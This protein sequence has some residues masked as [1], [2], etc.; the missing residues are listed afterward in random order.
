M[1]G[2]LRREKLCGKLLLIPELTFLKWEERV[3][4]AAVYFKPLLGYLALS[5]EVISIMQNCFKMVIS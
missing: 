2:I 5:M 4:K 1:N 3:G